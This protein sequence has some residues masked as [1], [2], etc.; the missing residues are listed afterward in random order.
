MAFSS[1]GVLQ[2]DDRERQAVDE[3]HDVRPAVVLALDD[4][5]LVDRQPVVVL[6][7]VEVDDARLRAGDRAVRAAVL[8]RDAVD[9][10]PV[11]GAVALDQRRRVGRGQLAEGVVQ[12]LGRQ[13]GV[14]PGERLAQP[15]LQDH[16]AVVRIAALGTRLPTAIS[17]PW[18]TL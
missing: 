1:A 6:R 3:E 13:V 9:E 7:V 8:D 12:R 16:V 11:E 17:G 15:P 5:E 18:R 10:H 14:E 4:G 2:L